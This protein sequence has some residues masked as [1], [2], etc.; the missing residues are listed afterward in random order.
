MTFL[1]SARIVTASLLL[2]TL[3][4]LPTSPARAEEPAAKAPEATASIPDIQPDITAPV[5]KK[6][7]RHKKKT[8]AKQKKKHTKS[9]RKQSSHPKSSKVNAMATDS[10]KAPKPPPMT[11][12]Q[13]LEILKTTRDLSGRNLSGQQLV[14]M[15]LSKCNMKGIDLSNANLERA[16]L[17]ESELDRADLSGANLRMVN[18]RASGM[19]AVN[20]ERATLDGAIWK[21]GRVCL[22]GS[23]GQCREPV[24]PAFTK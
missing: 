24:V 5:I 23:I 10:S 19:T 11:I 22:P 8:K 2:L 13:V 16:D 4:D 20:L 3:V 6:K 15:N 17:G 14:G 1:K 12:H 21:D 9:T 18:L 7:V